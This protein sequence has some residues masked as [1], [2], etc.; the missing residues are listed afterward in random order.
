VGELILALGFSFILSA[1]L[2][3]LLTP[4]IREWALSKGVVDHPEGRKAHPT[5]I[6]L[7]GGVAL[8][9][10]FM[11]ILSVPFY[12]WRGLLFQEK[13][14]LVGIIIGSSLIFLLGLY[15]DLKGASPVFKIGVQIIAAL[16]LV[17]FGLVVTALTSPL[18]QP[19]YL[20]AWGIPFTILWVVFI[21]N[22]LN[23]IDGL[24]GLAA[25]VSVIVAL[26]L[27]TVG[28]MREGVL[29]AFLCAGIAGGCLGF[30]RY[31]FPP[32]R[33]F[34]GDAGSMLLGF[35]L[36]SISLIRPLKTVAAVALFVP[37]VAL[38]VPI[39]E[40]FTTIIRRFWRGKSPLA[41]DRGHIHH[42]LLDLGF[43]PKVSV[44]TLY[45]I[46]GLFG[47]VCIGFV[48]ANPR[49]MV[50]LFFVL[51]LA[52]LVGVFKLHRLNNGRKSENG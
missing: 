37:I 10:T 7:L 12:F 8:Y 43:T 9:L 31:N 23:L 42:I 49:L 41:P 2:A 50:I 46:S 51:A 20:G 19:L 16:V 24:D 6:P 45:L 3:L 26:V 27:L 22:G 13:G 11:V 35:L 32:A 39:V 28:L 15:D 18:R 48:T 21:T 30:L 29:T 36:A 14:Y 47:L 40:S 34:M 25:G 17:N 52:S 44:I 33:I 38:G 5:S 1:A 4:R